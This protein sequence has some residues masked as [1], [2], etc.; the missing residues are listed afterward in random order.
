MVVFLGVTLA[1]GDKEAFTPGL[2]DAASLI[3]L[4]VVQIGAAYVLFAYAIARI[5]A[6]E[7]GLIGMVEPVLNPAWVFVFLAEDPGWWAVVGATVI[8]GAVGLRLT[9][10][11]RERKP[12]ATQL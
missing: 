3:F 2:G 11:E 9:L 4:G 7:A 1:L 8:L 6:L 12:G 5:T 10:S